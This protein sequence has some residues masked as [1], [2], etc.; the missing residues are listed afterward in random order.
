MSK[1]NLK[2]M[3]GL[4]HDLN[5][6]PIVRLP[7]VVKVQIGQPK[8]PAV[9]TWIDDAGQWRV[10]YTAKDGKKYFA[11]RGS[12]RREAEKIYDDLYASAL[13]DAPPALSKGGK[14]AMRAFPAKL[15]YFTFS[16]QNGNGSYLPDWE[17]IEAHGHCPTELEVVLMNDEAF[18]AQYQMWSASQL[19]CT[20]DGI[21]ANRVVTL[22]G[23]YE[24]EAAAAAA[25][26]PSGDTAVVDGAIMLA[27]TVVRLAQTP[28]ERDRMIG[29]AE[30]RAA[31]A[32]VRTDR[33]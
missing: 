25:A 5:G 3:Y 19:L 2:K 28:A 30:R 8:G 22:A 29:L 15:P 9:S 32:A 1:P 10:F 17:T 26:G 11:Y 23:G 4:T 6:A 21:T 13:N 27:R 7:R 16:R 12:D 18:E 33:A 24:K 20:G 31:S 14:C